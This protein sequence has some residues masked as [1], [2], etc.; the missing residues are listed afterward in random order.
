MGMYVCKPCRIQHLLSIEPI[1]LRGFCEICQKREWLAW[2]NDLDRVF[3]GGMSVAEQLR[4][5]ACGE[6]RR[7]GDKIL[8]AIREM[9]NE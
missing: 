2:T 7:P 8:A 4:R 6:S 5:R 1:F 9:I 3:P